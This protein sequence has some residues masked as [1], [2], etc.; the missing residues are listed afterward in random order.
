MHAVSS[1]AHPYHSIN[2]R[3][4]SALSISHNDTS[5]NARLN[6]RVFTGNQSGKLL[7]LRHP[8]EGVAVG[9]ALRMLLDGMKLGV[10]LSAAV[11]D[12]VRCVLGADVGDEVGVVLG[13]EVGVTV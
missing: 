7:G 3:V 4:G 10:E 12:E 5:C 2:G 11:G 8:P 1:A 6:K 9:L 13:D